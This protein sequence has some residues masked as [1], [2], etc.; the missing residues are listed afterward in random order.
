MAMQSPQEKASLTPSCRSLAS[1]REFD[2]F[3]D[4]GGALTNREAW[5]EA[6][7][8]DH[9][10]RKL[11]FTDHLRALVLLHTTEY[12]SAR[13]L[14]WAGSEDPLFAALGAGYEISV[15]G[16]GHAMAERPI[17][18]FERM[19]HQV[20]AAVAN[21][22]YQQL[23]GISTKEWSKI[24]DLF[25]SVDVFDAT[26][27]ELPPTLAEWHDTT[28]SKSSFKLQIK[29]D[30]RTRHLKEALITAPDGNDNEWFDDLLDLSEEDLS[31]GDSAGSRGADDGER[32]DLHLFDCGY[33]SIDTYHQ[34]DAVGDFFVTKLHGNIKPE[35]V[36]QRP[37]P[38]AAADPDQNAAGYRV[39]DD[40]YVRL[41]DD[42]K[43]SSRGDG[44]PR[45]WYRVLTVE[46]STGTELQILTN[47]RW[48]DAEQIC[49]LYRYRWSIEIL[50]RWLKDRMQLD[51]FIS[52]DPTGIVRQ[53]LTALVV[54]GLLAIYHQDKEFEEFS[55]KQLWRHL[56]KA[57][58]QAL[59]NYG[60]QY[61][62]RRLSPG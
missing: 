46:V 62:R 36:H 6:V 2:Q 26:K 7:D 61:E 4:G 31:E 21:L 25:D 27:V 40:C 18:P 10:V 5:A 60:R 53:T 30:G 13:D 22:P 45:R 3:L 29:L 12:E 38:D 51:H 58:H 9:N 20:Q 32:G 8:Y 41:G 1:P 14:A 47:L 33:W 17:E 59:V 49:R 28:E 24:A 42:R 54:W 57:Y 50:F 55:P 44:D 37:I 19:F 43:A 48:L 35:R 56:Q 23:R 39:I 11:D 52:E 15:P 34:I 16:F